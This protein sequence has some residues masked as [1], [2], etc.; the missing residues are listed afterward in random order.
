MIYTAH[1]FHKSFELVGT[2][3]LC[4]INTAFHKDEWIA[5]RFTAPRS[6]IRIFPCFPWITLAQASG[7]QISDMISHLGSSPTWKWRQADVNQ[8][9]AASLSRGF[10]VCPTVA[11]FVSWPPFGLGCRWV[12]V[13]TVGKIRLVK[14]HVWTLGQFTVLKTFRMLLN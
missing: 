9:P 14:D 7:M 8:P 13:Q 2:V 10:S 6:E 3:L 5:P 1:F 12:L 4:K 11:R